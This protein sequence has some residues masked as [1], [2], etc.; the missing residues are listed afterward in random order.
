MG[1]DP[2]Q[3]TR[4]LVDI[5]SVTGEEAAVA[6]ELQTILESI[7]LTVRR[8]PVSDQRFNLLAT[9]SGRTRVLF[10]SHIDTVPP[11]IPSSEDGEWIRGRGACDA[12]G[13][14]A[15]MIAATADLAGE[16]DGVGFLLVVG[17]ETDSIGAKRANEDL[18]VG[19]EY[20]VVGEPTDSVFVSGCKGAFT[21]RV[22]FRGVAAHSAYPER[23]D[24]AISR[25]TRAV[26][27]ID[28]AEWGFDERLGR[29][30]VNVG[31]IRGGG[32]ANVIPAEAE[33]ELM[34]RSVEEPDAVRARL[35]AIVEAEGGDIVESYGGSPIFLYVPEGE[36]SKVV[37]FGTD[38]PY[39]ERFGKRILFGP[40]SI[41]DAHRTDEKIRK[42]EILNAVG[43]Y[44]DLAR[45]LT[46]G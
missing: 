29:G 5:P 45:R 14:I 6:A 34:V 15:A 21:A 31:T 11:H 18:D 13:I 12:K 28:Q 33:L 24:S 8:H 9:G 42:S 16:V 3:L 32:S 37:A 43:M 39:L 36:P 1:I 20:V 10:C 2:I 4:R 30:T 25:L 26:V 44:R 46:G 17:E 35:A 7:G 38:A 41:L 40:G 23:G 19:S 27:A 22:R